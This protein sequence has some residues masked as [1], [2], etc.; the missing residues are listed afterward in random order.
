MEPSAEPEVLEELPP[1]A[2]DVPV[3][4]EMEWLL[5][6]EPE[7][8]EEAAAFPEPTQMQL[9]MEPASEPT[10]VEEPVQPD[11]EAEMVFRYTVQRGDTVSGIARKY[12]LTVKDLVEANDIINPNLIF[13]GQKLVI[14]GYMT[15]A[16][17][18]PPETE[19]APQPPAVDQYLAYT[20]Q[21]GDTLSS[22]SKRYGVTLRQLIEANDL[23]AASDIQ[24]GQPLLIPGVLAPP[25]PEPT[26][27]PPLAPTP[28]PAL[29]ID[30]DFPPLGPTEAI[31]GL[32][33]SYFA[34]GHADMRQ[35]VFDLLDS[36][37]FNAIVIDAKGDHGWISYPTQ[38]PLAREVGAD[39]PTAKDFETVMQQLKA[40][41]IYTIARIVTFKDTPFAKSYP[42]YAVKT[43]SSDGGTELWLDRDEL[44]WTDPFLKPVW[45]YNIQIAV[46]AAQ[47][48]FD[49]IQFN[50]VRFPN[51]SQ[52]GAPQFSQQATRESRV[53]AVS[54]FLS[55]ARGQ[56]SPLGVKISADTLG[57]TCWGPGD[58]LL[59]GHD[60]ERMGQYLDVLSP[61]LY[62]STFHNGIPG[63]KNAV[64]FPYEI[65][66]E[67]AR[68][69][70]DRLVSLN[71]TV[72]PWLQDFPDYRFDRREYGQEEVRAQILGCFDAGCSGFMVWDP[73][74]KYTTA[75]YA[76]VKSQA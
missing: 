19:A 9:E 11:P 2:K 26:P 8:V 17:P 60:I 39:H 10:I 33:A 58:V 43:N 30:P 24:V 70:V 68:R 49:E 25:R 12:G 28:A 61:I 66:Y 5:A 23:E 31:R 29:G 54:A 59:I 1:V 51:K 21:Q 47:L 36:T 62:P 16:P 40:R 72:R 27:E 34:I 63:Y 7:A 74:A 14:P 64:A 38:V 46:E 55:A 3:S 22:I 56:L 13:P 15:P 50:F 71:C 67:S 57:Y 52:M 45:D 73:H 4:D 42:E 48:G 32:Y 53:A 18:T 76:P 75:A 41:E 35:H 69:A 6:S 37:E 65:V 44:G 20:V